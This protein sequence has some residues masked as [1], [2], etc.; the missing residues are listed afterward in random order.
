MTD[1]PTTT[2]AVVAHGADDLRVE[3]QPM[4]VPGPDEAL[5]RMAYGGICGSDLHYWRHGAAGESVLRSPM[6]LGHEV[7]GTVVVAAADG[8]GP[9]AGTPVAVHPATRGTAPGRYPH[10]R[11]N[12][13]PGASYLGSAAYVPHTHGAFASYVALPTRLLRALPPGLDLRRAAL[14]EPAAVAWH[15]VDRAG[16]VRG[17]TALV[18]GAGPIGALAVAVLK[19]HGAARVVAVDLHEHALATARALGAD[20]TLPA[21]EADAIAAVEADVVLECSGSTPGLESA[22]RGAARGGTVVLVGLM[23]SGPQPA[24]LS[25]VVTRELDVRGSFRFNDE[26]DDV[27]A[28][29]A[30]GSLDAAPVISHELPLHQTLEAFTVAGDAARSSKVLLDLSPRPGEV[31]GSL[32]SSP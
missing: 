4:P 8:S 21:T 16:D 23:P 6:R 14:A 2:T 27:L 13:S 22:V 32:P 15:A 31:P 12:I 28:A 11:P 19:H 30:D 17:T 3:Q 10:D 18:V 1:L 5:V 25:L 20:E 7:S 26:I 9:A 29:M 24:L